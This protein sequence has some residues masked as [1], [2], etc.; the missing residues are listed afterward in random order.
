MFSDQ[1]WGIGRGAVP[2]HKSKQTPLWWRCKILPSLLFIFFSFYLSLSLSLSLNIIQTLLLNKCLT[3]SVHQ[4]L[5]NIFVIY[6]NGY[7]YSHSITIWSIV[8]YTYSGIIFHTHRQVSLL[9]QGTMA[10]LM[11]C[12]TIIVTQ[13]SPWQLLSLICRTTPQK[14]IRTIFVVVHRIFTVLIIYEGFSKR[15]LPYLTCTVR[16][17]SPHT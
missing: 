10:H 2:R 14:T 1:K 5:Q 6:N 11:P 13:P 7:N 4:Y 17:P 9:S 8:T 3:I 12:S 15:S 16:F